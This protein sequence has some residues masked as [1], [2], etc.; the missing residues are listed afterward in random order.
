GVSITRR[1]RHLQF[2]PHPGRHPLSSR[3]GQTRLAGSGAADKASRLV[4]STS[5]LWSRPGSYSRRKPALGTGSHAN[6][7]ETESLAEQR[8]FELSSL[9][10]ECRLIFAGEKY[11][12]VDKG[13]QNRPSVFTG[14][15]R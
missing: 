12:Q 10:R 13:G 2:Q 14:D 11:F 3:Y 5:L 4:A 1:L 8:G 9:S 7:S 15:Q 6:T